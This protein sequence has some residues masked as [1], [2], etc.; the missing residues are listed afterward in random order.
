MAS[1]GRDGNDPWMVPES[2]ARI[3]RNLVEAF[4]LIKNVPV[5]LTM[6]N[7]SSIHSPD[8]FAVL[9]C[10]RVIS[11]LWI[12]LAHTLALNT[13]A[14]LLNPEYVM[15]PTGFLSQ[16]VSQLYFQARFGVDTFL[17][18]S[19]FLVVTSLMKKLDPISVTSDK[20]F[21][22]PKAYQ[23]IPMLYLHRL[24]RIL[25]LY[26]FCLLLWWKIGIW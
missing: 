14:G 24:M 3:E 18:I 23:W 4:S 16:W 20:Q 8:R 17:F 9:D 10:L 26:I 13:A 6:Y 5:I 1:A 21:A 19:G 25:P 12:M 2:F 15:P 11:I 7:Q 22:R